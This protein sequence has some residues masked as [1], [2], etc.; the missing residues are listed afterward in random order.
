VFAFPLFDAAKNILAEIAPSMPPDYWWVTA[1]VLFILALTATIDAFTAV[2]PDILIFLGLLA[3][4]ATQGMAISW[5]IAGQHLRQAL[6]AA[7]A[8]WALNEIWYWKF[9][10]DALGMGDAKWTML[11]VACFGLLPA[12]YAWGIGAILAL[13]FL[14]VMQ[15]T[16]RKIKHVTFAPFLLAGLCVGLYWIKFA[17]DH[18]G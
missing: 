13:A 15:I 1:C 2:I 7:I 10:R 17:V 6:C 5:E 14:A 11:A 4:V 12:L 3:L 9:H 16:R 8:I 18:K